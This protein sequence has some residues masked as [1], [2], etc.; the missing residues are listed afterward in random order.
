M[1]H[2]MRRS[3]YSQV[4][5]S[6]M[7]PEFGSAEKEAWQLAELANTALCARNAMEGTFLFVGMVFRMDGSMFVALI[8]IGN[9]DVAM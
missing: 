6:S 8:G 9:E 1:H 2:P 5:S 4:V 7:L 3:I